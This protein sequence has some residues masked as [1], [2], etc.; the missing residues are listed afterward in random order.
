MEIDSKINPKVSVIVPLYNVEDYLAECLDCIIS[1]TMEEVEI[2]CVNDAA[3]DCSPDIL[4]EYAHKDS[5]IKIITHEMNRGL[6]AARNS[7]VDA[8][9]AAFITFIDSDDL[10]TPDFIEKLY[11][12]IMLTE[13][14]LSWCGVTRIN[15][16]GVPLDIWDTPSG[17][18]T[19]GE[20]LNNKELYPGILP[21]CNKMFRK[22]LYNGIIQ[23]AIVNEDQPALAEYLL[24]SKNVVTISDSNYYYRKRGN[25]LSK[26]TNHPPHLWDDFFQA[27][28]AFI[29]TLGEKYPISALR[30]QIILRHYSLLR[31]FEF[32]DLN[33]NEIRK[34]NLRR[35]HYHLK[36]DKMQLRE[37]NPN[38][39]G[40]INIMTWKGLSDKFYSSLLN[41]A[42]KAAL[43]TWFT[44]RSIASVLID[45]FKIVRYTLK[46]QFIKLADKI[47]IQSLTFVSIL[48]RISQPGKKIWLIG[49]RGDTAQENGYYYFRYLNASKPDI[50]S[51]YIINKTSAQHKAVA[52]LGKTL[53]PNS[54]KHKLLF[55]RSKYYVTAHNHYCIPITS[56]GKTRYRIPTNTTNVFLPHGITYADVSAFYG[57]KASGINLFLCGAEPEY[58]YI[59]DV[60]GFDEEE[61]KYTGL[62]RFDDYF[63]IHAEKQVLIMPTWRRYIYLSKNKKVSNEL[64]AKSSYYKIYQSL[65]NNNELIE[66]LERYDYRLVFYPHYEIQDYITLFSSHSDRINICTSKD[67]T[68]QSLL[69]ESSLLIT[70]TSSVSFDFAYMKKP[71]L[72]YFLDREEVKK[73]HIQPGYFDHESMGFGEISY[74]E[75]QLI[76]NLQSK[77]KSGCNLE[78]KYEDRINNFFPLRDRNNCERIFNEIDKV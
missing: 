31:R 5:R 25:T 16:H 4:N 55:L 47:E 68:V 13:A 34:E 76:K 15:E 32:F 37:V 41:Y 62:A 61:V 11:Q 77:L 63:D 8:A 54:L 40:F 48:L 36:E 18:W 74:S 14:D 22:S 20:I 28:S 72:Y 21:V 53:H 26:P 9:T 43:S 42:L 59:K 33:R 19:V 46:I 17:Y 2:I 71:I 52:K 23:P 65:L 35:V 10:V 39:Y 6:G 45:I 49:E 73:E 29:T 1:Q 44:T 60:F 67:N 58:R 51:H 66:I 27:H 64:F 24:K 56:F 12:A 38:M 69:K 75:S 57:K 78:K 7:G 30:T 70:D 50:V 3:E